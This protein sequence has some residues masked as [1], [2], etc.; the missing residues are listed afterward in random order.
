L[1]RAVE[2]STA[3]RETAVGI[4]VAAITVCV[5][6]GTVITARAI[7][8]TTIVAGRNVLSY[9]N[10]TATV[11]AYALIIATACAAARRRICLRIVI[12]TARII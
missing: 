10:I 5:A 11:S 9:P 7:M 8:A 4:A 12:T 3:N 2:N 6:A 1:R